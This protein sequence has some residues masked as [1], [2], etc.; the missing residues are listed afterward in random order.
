MAVVKA[1]GYGHGLKTVVDALQDADEFAVTDLHEASLLRELGIQQPIT[2][3]SGVFNESDLRYMAE[4]QICAT[5][6]DDAQLEILTKSQGDYQLSVW[7][8]V[9]TGM[10]R[11]GFSAEKI[12]IIYNN[13]N[14]IHQIKTI[15][16]LS[17]LA[18]AD[19]VN[20][21]TNDKQCQLFRELIKH[22]H[23]PQ[24]SLLN[25][26]G[27]CQ[28]AK[29]EYSL[30]RPGLML[31]GASPLQSKTAQELE[32]QAAMEFKAPIISVKTVAAGSAIGYGSTAICQHDTKV[33]VIACGYADG[34][35]RAVE[36]ANVLI[37]SVKNAISAPIIGRISM[38]MLT[39]DVTEQNVK[40]GDIV[41]L[42]GAEHPIEQI[43]RKSNTISYELMTGVAN[44][45]ERRVMPMD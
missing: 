12:S 42:W 36:G 45:V 27:I 33:A 3:L 41:T 9:D 8:K 34:Y 38:D 31:Y 1:D 17:H 43:A 28:L 22:T 11:L 23:C 24:A 25:S 40:V 5:I 6:Y 35:P 14:S 13:L 32:L 26:G 39:V 7:L 19:E 20:H 44:R 16:L 15:R 29:H 18:N 30:V 4:N 37:D 10:G 2:V 21:I